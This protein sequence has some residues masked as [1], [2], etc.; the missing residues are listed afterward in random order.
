MGVEE[1]GVDLAR[2]EIGGGRDEDEEVV[3][4]PNMKSEMDF[5]TL[6][7]VAVALEA[8]RGEDGFIPF[9]GVDEGTT[10]EGGGGGVAH[11]LNTHKCNGK[12]P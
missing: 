11:I 4:V 6:A 7:A 5:V 1:L 2:L 3:V 10:A 12:H 8:D 9:L